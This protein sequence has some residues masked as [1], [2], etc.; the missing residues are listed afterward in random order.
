MK[1]CVSDEQVKEPRRMTDEMLV[2]H[3]IKQNKALITLLTKALHVAN[4]DEEI[5][6]A[7]NTALNMAKDT[8]DW[9][10]SGEALS[11]FREAGENSSEDIDVYAPE[12]Y[13][14]NNLDLS[15]LEETPEWLAGYEDAKKRKALAFD[16]SNS[17][18]NSNVVGALK[19]NLL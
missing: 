7:I 16:K 13:A 15:A 14:L 2:E 9:C 19:D 5:S 10:T 4:G 8:L 11:S 18:L 12:L 3:S 17:N 1:T 6:D